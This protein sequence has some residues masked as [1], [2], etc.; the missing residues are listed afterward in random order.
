MSVNH[1]TKQLE[2]IIGGENPTRFEDVK[3]LTTEEYFVGNQFSI[4]AFKSKYS[5]IS[6]ATNNPIAPFSVSNSLAL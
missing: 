4:D 2:D 5:L 6:S 1:T 3:N